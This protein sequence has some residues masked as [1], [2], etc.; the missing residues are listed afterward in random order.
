MRVAVV[1]A[2]LSGV[3]VAAELDR[4]GAEV[5]VLEAT[6]HA[7]GV[8][9]TVTDSGYLLEPAGGAFL[10][11]HP[12]LDHFVDEF[13]LDVTPATG[14]RRR[15]LAGP[16]GLRELPGGPAAL[17]ASGVLSARGV[18]RLLRE[19]TV[20]S[21][22][23]DG[24]TLAGFCERRF[25]PEAGMLAAHLAASGVFGGDPSELSVAAAFARLVEMEQAD[26]S[27]LRA[28]L[29][30]R[31][32]RPPGPGPRLMVPTDGMRAMAGQLAASVDGGV[33]SGAEVTT[34]RR[35]EDA[36]LVEAGDDVVRADHVVMAIDPGAARRIAPEAV[37]GLLD[38]RPSAPVAVVG[39]GGPEDGL[40]LPP[41]FGALTVPGAGMATLGALF[42]SSY[43]PGRAPAGHSL[44]KLIV[45]GARHPEVE[46]WDDDYVAKVAGTELS[47]MLG[48]PVDVEW[49]R[50]IRRRIPQYNVGHRRWL[51]RV[52]RVTAAHPGLYL[53]GW[54][55][56]GVGIGQVAV[57]ALATV[58]RIAAS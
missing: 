36:W 23:S 17:L 30:A 57:D 14:A 51:E 33:R 29:E 22:S 35:F 31:R 48:C 52:D 32:S 11:P 40:A 38:R 49:V 45:G 28:A 12:A 25:G 16:E 43:A 4:R 42:E 37:S 7:G 2:G 34:V 54:A 6:D 47:T 10:L 55:Y 44:A 5:T 53:T 39:L 46:R 41:G 18:L 56:R 1:G 50:V 9:D 3:M 8:A 24:E 13:G 27:V 21:T 26:G 19:V 20:D 15:Y 58:D